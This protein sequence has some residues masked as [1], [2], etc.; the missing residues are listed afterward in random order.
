[1]IVWDLETGG[2]IKILKGF[3]HKRDPK[4]HSDE[5]LALALSD[6]CNFLASGGKDR[7]IHIWDPNTFTWIC[8]LK[9]H[10]DSITG[11]KFAHNSH[12]LY[13]CSLDRTV[14]VWEVSDRVILDS[15]HGHYTGVHDI[16]CYHNDKALT[17]G[18][19]CSVRMWK[20]SEETQLVY[21]GHNGSIDCIRIVNIEIFITGGQDGHLCIWKTGKKKPVGQLS[22]PHN[23]CWISSLAV[24]KNTDLLASGSCNG[25]INLYKIL[26]NS[27]QKLLEIPV[28]GYIT[29]LEFSKSGKFLVACISPDHKLGRWTSSQKVK[30][31][32][33]VIPLHLTIPS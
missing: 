24:L 9:G 3:R 33:T 26:S 6:D 10:K 16:D 14:K 2:K 29:A 1:M 30:P 19:D 18:F 32:L 13:S 22:S 31:G 21:N 17:C 20:T 5:I 11:L 4:S 23:G 15:L 27:I 7:I 12:T 28:N 8:S 25:F